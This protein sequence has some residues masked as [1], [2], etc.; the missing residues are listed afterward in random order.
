MHLDDGEGAKTIVKTPD[1][2]DLEAADPEL[3]QRLG[4]GVRVIKQYGGTF[5]IFPLFLL[6]GP[7]VEGLSGP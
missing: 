7:S 5:D 1:G 6:T 4:E 2:A 3:A